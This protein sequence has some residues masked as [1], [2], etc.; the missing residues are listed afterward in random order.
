MAGRFAYRFPWARARRVIVLAAAP[1]PSWLIPSSLLRSASSMAMSA[2][3][4]SS[5]LMSSMNHAKA[6]VSR[7]VRR[8][9][10]PIFRLV[11]ARQAIH[12][13]VHKE[14]DDFLRGQVLVQHLCADRRRVL[15]GALAAHLAALRLLFSSSSRQP[16]SSSGSLMSVV[17]V[18]VI[19]A[20]TIAAFP[21]AAVNHHLLVAATRGFARTREAMMVT[22]NFHSGKYSRRHEMVGYSLRQASRLSFQRAAINFTSSVR[23]PTKT[24]W[25]APT[26]APWACCPIPRRSNL[27]RRGHGMYI[28]TDGQDG[29]EQEEEEEEE[30]GRRSV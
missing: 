7:E 13:V 16:S 15:V 14:V 26:P 28:W 3:T 23:R 18:V 17:V 5:V 27:N 25:A 11:L 6:E 1:P 4:F 9:R 19:V 20:L 12:G 8:Q 30:E 29:R 21:A 22:G 2:R 24:R 10:R